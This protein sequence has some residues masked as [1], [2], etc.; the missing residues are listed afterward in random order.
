MFNCPG[1][2]CTGIRP[3]KEPLN[4]IS[5]LETLEHSEVICSPGQTPAF[6]LGIVQ[7]LEHQHRVL[8]LECSDILTGILGITYV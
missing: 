2:R 1:G 4:S 8:Q 6:N 5:V 7:I 3:S